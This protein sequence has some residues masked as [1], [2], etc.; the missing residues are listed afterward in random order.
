MER[1]A[2]L[3]ADVPQFKVIISKTWGKENEM[4]QLKSELAVL[5]SNTTIELAP[6]HDEN[7]GMEVKQKLF[8]QNQQD[9][10]STTID[11]PLSLIK[12]LW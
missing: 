5:D 3:K 1:T 2:K 10:E 12:H 11:S 7:N 4:K 6:K 8:Q 9:I